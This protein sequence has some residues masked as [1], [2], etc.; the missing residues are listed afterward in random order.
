LNERPSERARAGKPLSPDD[1]LAEREAHIANLRRLLLNSE[2]ARAAI[3]A[4]L[5]ERDGVIDSL[6]SRLSAVHASSSWKITAPLRIARK[7]VSQIWN[8]MFGLRLRSL[9]VHLAHGTV[10]AGS[11]ASSY[12]AWQ[13]IRLAERLTTAAGTSNVW[14]HFITVVII[15]AESDAAGGLLRTLASLRR[16]SYRNIELLVVGAQR[17]LS[18]DTADFSEYRGLSLEPTLDPLDI[19]TSAATDQLWRGSYLF[20]A[21][22]GTEFAP[23]TFAL[24]NGALNPKVGDT[25]P[26][27]VLCDHDRLIVDG[28][29]T[30]P[31]F[32]PGWDPDFICA[33]DYIETAFLASRALVLAQ[34]TARPPT[35]LHQWLCGIAGGLQQPM[36][37]HIAEPLVHMPASA[38]EPALRSVAL[39]LRP[40]AVGAGLPVMAIIIPTRNKPELL[41]RCVSFLEFPNCFRPE[42]VIIDNGSDE[43]A[44]TTIYSELRARHGARIVQMDRPFNFSRMVNLGVAASSSEVVLLLNNDVEIT[45][46]G[47]L[48]Q[49]L[50]NALRP[51][52]GVVGSRLM[53]P[54]G[55]VQHAGM[56]L[57]PGPTPEHRI[58]AQHVLRGASPATDGYL[59][60]L[61]TVRNYQCVTGALLAVRREVF[62][63]VGGFDELLPIVFNDVDFCLRVRRAGLRVIT[64]PLN[65]VIHFESATRGADRSNWAG[66]MALMAERWP[67]A[68]NHDPYRHPWVD[69]GDIPEARFP[70]SPGWS[71]FESG[72]K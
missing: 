64:L 67:D 5:T 30:A 62:Q 37:S 18:V 7:S 2:E 8:R 45:A 31:S 60:Q 11:I 29:L 15:A 4:G 1:A 39:T 16:Q 26:D 14:N 50:A 40:T 59:Y 46:P 43:A 61:R 32:A 63:H 52:V 55:R 13:Q 17:E 28:Q 51:E 42:L 3:K 71:T 34:R 23:D 33:F 69:V 56:L 48:E 6:Q 72:S 20:F 54:N 57:R 70:W 53:Y 41:K 47:L 65:G 10:R 21:R 58:W 19:L 36:T 38:P 68:I 35:S 9:L 12:P 24:L 44:V 22:A 25:P 49:I 66:V 27:L